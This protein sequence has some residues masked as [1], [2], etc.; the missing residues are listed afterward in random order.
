MKK[1]ILLFITSTILISCGGNKKK[2]DT[3]ETTEVVK[4]KYDLTIDAIYPKDDSI[5]VFYQKDNYFQYEKPTTMKIKG[6]PIVQRFT[7]NLPEGEKVENLK[8]T[9]STNKDQNT[10]DIKNITITNGTEVI[11]GD[12]VKYADYFLT[13]ETFSWDLKNSR[14]NLD[15]TKKYPPSLV[16]NEKLLSLLGK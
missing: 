12:K 4:D 8:I 1:L 9:V 13:D 5:V 2:E 16:G 6:S 15:H 14:Y 7:L 10:L 3:T 11:D